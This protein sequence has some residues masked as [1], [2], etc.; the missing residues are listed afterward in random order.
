[1]FVYTVYKERLIDVL[2]TTKPINGAYRV[3]IQVFDLLE[4]TRDSK[5]QFYKNIFEINRRF[6]TLLGIKQI[7]FYPKN[8]EV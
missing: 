6:E 7:V 2:K 5:E 8:K 1:M 4:A 3:E